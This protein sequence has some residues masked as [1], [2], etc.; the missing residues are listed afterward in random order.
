MKGNGTKRFLA[1]FM[2]FAMIAASGVM[3]TGMFLFASESDNSL[4]TQVVEEVAVDEDAAEETEEVAVEAESEEAS[5]EAT[6]ESAEEATEA[7]EDAAATETASDEDAAAEETAS[8]EEATEAEDAEEEEA[9]EAVE[10]ELNQS[11]TVDGIEV[12]VKADAGVFPEDAKIAVTK[13]SGNSLDKVTEAVADEATGIVGSLVAFDIT[14][15]DADGNEIQPDTSKGEVKVS[16]AKSAVLEE[17]GA[18]NAADLQIYH[19][20]DSLSSAEALDTEVTGSAVEAEADHFSIFVAGTEYATIEAAVNAASDGDTIDLGEGTYALSGQLVLNKGL[21]F[22]NGTIDVSSAN[23]SGFYVYASNKEFTFKDVTITD[24]GSASHT[25]AA[26]YVYGAKNV[27]NIEGDTVIEGRK[28]T[29]SAGGIEMSGT[30]GT[31]NIKGGKLTGLTGSAGGAICIKNQ[32]T[33]NMSGGEI[34]GCTATSNGGAINYNGYSGGELNITGGKITNNTSTSNVAGAINAYYGTV[35]VS[36]DAEITGNNTGL[37]GGAFY[38]LATKINVSGNVVISGNTVPNTTGAYGGAFYITGGAELNIEDGTFENNQAGAFGETGN[39]NGG[40]IYQ[41]QKSTVNISGGTFRNNQTVAAGGVLFSH[42]GTTN[43]TGGT[44]I[45]NKANNGAVIWNTI[46]NNLTITGGDFKNNK[47]GL[48]GGVIFNQNG[49]M[50]ISGVTFESNTADN[51][52]GGVIKSTY[53]SSYGGNGVTIKIKDCTFKKNIANGSAHV[54]GQGGAI[55][56]ELAQECT[57][58]NCKFIENTANVGGAFYGPQQ[59]TNM[60]ECTFEGNKAVTNEAGKEAKTGTAGGIG[61][62]IYTFGADSVTKT[63]ASKLNLTSCTFTSNTAD[64]SGGAIA[65]QSGAEYTINGGS[66]TSNKATHGGAIYSGGSE[67]VIN[68]GVTF[69]SNEANEEGGAIYVRE[70]N[71]QGTD[72]GSLKVNKGD[73]TG[74]KAKNGGA[75]LGY[76]VPVTVEYGTFKGNE[77][78]VNGGVFYSSNNTLTING[79]T[80]TENKAEANSGVAHYWKATGNTINGGT[81]TNNTARDAG[82]A[83]ASGSDLKVTGGKFQSNTATGGGGAF[84]VGNYVVTSKDADGNEVTTTTD[85]AITISGGEVTLNNA[86]YGGGL[87]AV[88]GTATVADGVKLCN[89]HGSSYGDDIDS[90]KGVTLNLGTACTTET[91]DDCGDKID[92][93][94][95]DSNGNRWDYTCVGSSIYTKEIKAGKY[96][97]SKCLKAAHDSKKYTVIFDANGGSGEMD[98]QKFEISESKELSENEFTRSGYTFIGWNTEKDGSGTSYND[99]QEVSKLAGADEEITLYAQWSQQTYTIKYDKNS[100]SGS[101]DDQTVGVGVSANL[102]ANEFT[103]A[104]YAFKGW[105]TKADGS[106]TSYD[107]KASVKDLAD[108][109]GSITLYAQWTAEEHKATVRYQNESGETVHASATVTFNSGSDGITIDIPD[110]V[111]GYTPSRVVVNGKTL[112]LSDGENTKRIQFTGTMSASDFDITVI[113]AEEE[114]DDDNVTPAAVTDDDDDDNTTATPAATTP[115]AAGGGGGAAAAP[116]AAAPATV[117]TVDANDDGNVELAQVEDVETPAALLEDEEVCNLI[118]FLLMAIAMVVEAFNNKNSKNHKKRME[119]LLA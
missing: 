97:D 48:N 26:I 119:D 83:W 3:N 92:G 56:S 65:S 116:A 34:T 114:D 94:Y 68:D 64:D 33:L 102:N 39:A 70:N 91:L 67:L 96:T 6:D 54:S 110:D 5:G 59:S 41:Y 76:K 4:D 75:I 77:A 58:D 117:V 16:F 40:M 71:Y 14:V 1:L 9:E 104:G 101:M 49:T 80:Y 72:E 79:G 89:N 10:A 87:L 93:W 47:A 112:T 50:D 106:G 111:D 37:Y 82:V 17:T 73:F 84:I 88:S 28:A 61:G 44:F 86:A 100:G 24:D 63:T 78:S 51:G 21:T 53:N 98:N 8:D 38:A 113:Y 81:F 13:V 90:R 85:G 108:A 7:S 66:F 99:K 57:I 105:N 45:E 12:T 69:T 27:I 11:V 36:G 29:S 20:N 115:A 23:P 2:A 18:E 15:T 118:P 95:D 103:R 30:G 19:M 62:A 46:N 60:T 109:D 32:S 31:L 107:N 42:Q 35:N 25:W 22:Q 43:I 52:Y 55:W 74:N